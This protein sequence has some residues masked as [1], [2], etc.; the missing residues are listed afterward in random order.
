MNACRL[1]K[2]SSAL[3]L[4]SLIVMYKFDSSKLFQESFFLNFLLV[5]LCV[6]AFDCIKACKKIL[7]ASLTIKFSYKR[8]SIDP[9]K[10]LEQLAF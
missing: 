3:Q 6:H 7:L 1:Q 9:I 8:N 10:V 2:N 5:E 4:L